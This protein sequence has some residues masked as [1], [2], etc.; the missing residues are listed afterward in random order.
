M[1]VVE[2]AVNCSGLYLPGMLAV[3]TEAKNTYYSQVSHR[4][5]RHSLVGRISEVEL[6]GPRPDP[7][8]TT[9]TIKRADWQPKTATAYWVKP[10]YCH[11]DYHPDAPVSVPD[12][13]L[14]L[15]EYWHRFY[16]LETDRADQHISCIGQVVQVSQ[17]FLRQLGHTQSE[18]RAVVA[19][20]DKSAEQSFWLAT[21]IVSANHQARAVLLRARPEEVH[22]AP[23]SPSYRQW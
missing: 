11:Y 17:S 19:M 22:P 3:L 4:T 20:I 16:G 21:E 14:G 10:L 1:G 8:K 13:F 5:L 9:V 2:E 6:N 23:Y 7:Y 15:T 18:C 12:E